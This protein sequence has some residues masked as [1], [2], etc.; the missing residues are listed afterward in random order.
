MTLK[1]SF[2]VTQLA[3]DYRNEFKQDVVIDLVCYRRRG[4]NEADEPAATQPRMYE[5]IRKHPT[6]RDLYV[7]QLI[8]ES[9]ISEDDAKKFF[10]DYRDKLDR[11]DHVV[12]AL[13]KEPNTE[14]YV[15]WT[16]YLGHEWT[17]RC[18]TSVPM[19]T[20][21]ELGK[22]ISAVPEGFSIQRQVKKIMEDRSKMTQGRCRS[23]GATRR[24]WPMQRFSTRGTRSGFPVRIPV[25]GPSPIVIQCCITRKMVLNTFLLNISGKTSRVL[26]SMTPCCPRKRRWRSNTGIRRRHRQR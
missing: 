5:K 8:Q 22:K 10:E 11:G 24:R 13:V 15:D 6:T 1:R 7:K 12:D 25:A 3:M 14:L 16:P 18:K 4:H 23:T 26:R 9:V 19:K 2:F 20:L 21:Q 17:A